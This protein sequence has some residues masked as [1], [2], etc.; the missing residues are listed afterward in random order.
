MTTIY[1]EI[2]TLLTRLGNYTSSKQDQKNNKVTLINYN[3]SFVQWLTDDACITEKGRPFQAGIVLGK[4]HYFY[5]FTEDD[6]GIN[7]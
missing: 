2:N 4:N 6:R 3:T 1:I 7:L 5:A